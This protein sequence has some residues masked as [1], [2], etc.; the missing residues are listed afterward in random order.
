MTDVIAGDDQCVVFIFCGAFYL[1]INTGNFFRV[2]V[3]FE[4]IALKG[5]YSKY[6]FLDKY[7]KASNGEQSTDSSDEQKSADK[8]I[9][10]CKV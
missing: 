3:F 7:Y 5:V 9:T 1:L 6:N 8:S 10:E 4:H 2:T